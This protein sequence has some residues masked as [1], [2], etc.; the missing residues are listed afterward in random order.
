MSTESSTLAEVA[1]AHRYRRWCLACLFIYSNPM[2][3]PDIAHQLTVWEHHDIEI[4]T[5]QYRLTVYNVLCN[6]HLP[7]LR[8]ANLVTYDQED[9]EVKLGPK[10]VQIETVINDRLAAEIRTLLEAEAAAIDGSDE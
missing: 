6:D 7:A 10:A 8:E 4:D 5:R 1:L 2:R 9:G 3:L